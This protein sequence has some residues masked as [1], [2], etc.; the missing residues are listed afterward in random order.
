[1]TGGVSVRGEKRG[2]RELRGYVPQGEPSE[3]VIEEVRTCG[4]HTS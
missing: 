3:A 2:V 4:K 1:M